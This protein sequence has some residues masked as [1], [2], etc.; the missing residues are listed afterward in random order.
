MEAGMAHLT[1]QIGASIVIPFRTPPG[2]GNRRRKQRTGT[3]LRWHALREAAVVSG[4]LTKIG[5]A[6]SLPQFGYDDGDLRRAGTPKRGK[7]Q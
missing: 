6:I 1:I 5:R 7:L 4:N 3:R 2:W